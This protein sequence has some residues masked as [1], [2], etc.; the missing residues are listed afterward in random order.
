MQIFNIDFEKFY[1]IARAYGYSRFFDVIT[2][3]DGSQVSPPPC[4]K[5]EIS[6]NLHKNPVQ[7][8]LNKI[9]FNHPTKKYLLIFDLDGTIFRKFD[10]LYISDFINNE[11]YFP[12]QTFKRLVETN[13]FAEAKLKS[14]VL[15]AR[16]MPDIFL[17]NQQNPNTRGLDYYSSFGYVR[18]KADP[19]TGKF[20]NL[21]RASALND[22]QRAAG[23][24][25]DSLYRQLNLIFFMFQG[26]TLVGDETGFYIRFLKSDSAEKREQVLSQIRR[27]FDNANWA[28]KLRNPWISENEKP[29]DFEEFWSQDRNLVVFNNKT[30]AIQKDF[31]IDFIAEQEKI[32]KDTQIFYFGDSSSDLVAMK[33]LK[34]QFPNQVTNIRIG[35]DIPDSSIHYTF[36]DP[37]STQDFIKRLHAKA[38][39]KFLSNF[40][41]LSL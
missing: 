30:F 9:N 38:K 21:Y 37:T 28:I 19:S 4:S 23:S 36:D 10:N 11:N 35:S 7:L 3:S 32:D 41:N 29:F 2:L 20:H 12:S 39:N 26:I 1:K 31:G 18:H 27:I 5:K 13:Q 24:N 17:M 25:W 22:L 40:S 15:T 6:P 33:K 8:V 34:E 14:V 16:A